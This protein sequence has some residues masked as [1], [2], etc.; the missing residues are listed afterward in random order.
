MITPHIPERFLRHIWQHLHFN[1]SNLCTADGRKVEILFPGRPNADA[2]PD[3]S[4]ARIRIGRITYIGDVELHKTAEEWRSHFHQT[5]Q[6]YNRVILHVVLTSSPLAPP[7]RTINKR[8]LPLLVLHPYLDDTL[9]SAWRK[10]ITDDR[11]ERNKSIPCHERNNTVP[12]DV[13]ERWIDRL[14]HERVEMKIRRFEER[15]KE[16]VD[17]QKLIIHEPYPRY[18]GNPDEIPP[19]EREYTRRDYSNKSLWEQLLYEATMEGLGYS[20]NSGA[21]LE[22]AQSMRLSAIR[23]QGFADPTNAMS[24]LFGAAGLIPSERQTVD[25]E[26]RAYVRVLRRKWKALRHLYRGKV[27]QPGDW[28]FFRLRPGNFPTARLAAM[29]FLLPSIF[30]E[31]GFRSI[32]SLFK[33]EGLSTRERVD[34]SRSIFHFQADQFWQHRYRFDRHVSSRGVSLGRERINDLLVN[35]VL[36]VVLLYARLFNAHDVRR[37]AH[38]MLVALPHIQ[39]NSTTRVMQRELLKKRI[40]LTSALSQQGCIHLYTLYC[41]HERCTECEV[42]KY[43]EM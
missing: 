32:I 12:A 18:Y 34:M 4:D 43:L 35:G 20:K 22:L 17:E 6:H 5:D 19:P 13:M 16:L 24:L 42:G 28:M 27:L 38:A 36:P 21:F 15:L 30:S 33:K 37:N 11:H 31:E 14:A 2:G 1:V 10:A 26:A 9:R 40:R 3:F 29:C 39:E 23:Q 25:R 8:E 7:A 41:V